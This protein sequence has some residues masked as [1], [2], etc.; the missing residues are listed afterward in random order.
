MNQEP[1]SGIN[2]NPRSEADQ[3]PS[4]HQGC[5][6]PLPELRHIACQTAAE[7]SLHTIVRRPSR[8]CRACIISHV[9]AKRKALPQPNIVIHV[10]PTSVGKHVVVF[11]IAHNY[12]Y[13]ISLALAGLS[14]SPA[15]PAPP[16]CPRRPRPPTCASCSAARRS[17]SS[18]LCSLSG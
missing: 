5:T 2:E 11:L 13:E 3:T 14:P 1:W 17:S 9:E 15:L 16:R 10:T 6:W 12:L 4:M 18:G 8:N 7:P